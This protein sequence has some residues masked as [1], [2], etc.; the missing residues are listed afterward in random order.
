MVDWGGLTI[1]MGSGRFSEALTPIGDRQGHRRAGYP[2]SRRRGAT[3]T[4]GS[5]SAASLISGS[6]VVQPY[7]TDSAPT[8]DAW[9]RPADT[10]TPESR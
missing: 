7:G 4:L 5:A 10:A 8:E 1:T 9:P 6:A 2:R 3:P